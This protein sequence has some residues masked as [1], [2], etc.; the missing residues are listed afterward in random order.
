MKRANNRSGKTA[1]RGSR[2]TAALPKKRP[3]GKI[4]KDL[5][6]LLHLL[7]VNQIELQHQNH[8]LRIAQEELEVSRNKYVNLFD[9][10][11]VEY[12]ILDQNGGITDANMRASK[13]FGI[14]RG[15]LIGRLFVS[16][17]PV[18]ERGIFNSFIKSIYSSPVKQ[19]CEL[20]VMD[21]NK[22]ALRVR[23]E[24]LEL[25]DPLELERKCTVAVISIEK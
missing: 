13:K 1:A 5:E 2:K 19:T 15:K 16:F 7:E 18:A 10:S 11:P 23:L 21:S 25:I 17:I 12:F 14:A 9:F 24:G 20:A 3:T 22:R 6:R 4:I 8:E